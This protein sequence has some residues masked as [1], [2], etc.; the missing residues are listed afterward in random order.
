MVKCMLYFGG[1]GVEELTRKLASIGS[2]KSSIF[3]GHQTCMTT[4]IKD[5]VAPFITK[6]HCFAHWTNLVVITLSNVPLLHQLE[7]IL[8]NIYVF[9]LHNLK[10]F[11]E[12]QKLANLLNTKDNKIL[13]NVKTHWILM[14]SPSKII[15]Y[16][17]WPLIV[18]MH[19]ESPNN[20]TANKN[21][22]A[23]CD[24]ELILGLPCLLPLFEC[25]HKLIKIVQGRDVFVCNL[26]KAIKLA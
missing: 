19:I 14:L 22:N 9:Y 16:E 8:Q 7:G 24:V 15:Y 5:K 12:F 21:L 25:V 20:D 4:H 17:Y 10:K 13:W 23:R 2:D 26:V 18:K 3:Q 1:L 6:M 11:V